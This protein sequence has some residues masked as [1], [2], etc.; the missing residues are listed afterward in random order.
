MIA[1]EA[2]KKKGSFQIEGLLEPDMKQNGEG[3]RIEGLLEIRVNS[4][5][6]ND[7]RGSWPNFTS[8]R[9]RRTSRM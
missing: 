1:S 9:G 8:G 3:F 2:V 4:R 7:R 6:N 5:Q